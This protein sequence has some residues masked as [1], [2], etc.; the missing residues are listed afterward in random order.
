M[1]AK[2]Y[3]ILEGMRLKGQ[4]SEPILAAMEAG[5]AIPEDELGGL[6]G[7]FDTFF[8]INIAGSASTGGGTIANFG[9][10]DGSGG[11]GGFGLTDAEAQG[12]TVVGDFN[13][14]CCFFQI[15][16]A[17]GDGNMFQNIMNIDIAMITVAS[18]AQLSSV[19]NAVQ[20]M[21]Q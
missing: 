8:L 6:R 21:I 12:L 16:Q 3:M 7:G 20:N 15:N 2:D 18:E 14:G 17:T 11:E 9:L 4:G 10:G 1:R 13:G 19:V 5:E